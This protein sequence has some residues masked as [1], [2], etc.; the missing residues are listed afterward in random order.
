MVVSGHGKRLSEAG[1]PAGGPASGRE[2]VQKDGRRGGSEYFLT[3][4]FGKSLDEDAAPEASIFR[5]SVGA[6]GQKHQLGRVSGGEAAGE[7]ERE[8][9]ARARGVRSGEQSPGGR[10]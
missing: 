5:E 6:R 10:L 7:L 9:P 3:G 1:S 2:Q 4:Y 8:L